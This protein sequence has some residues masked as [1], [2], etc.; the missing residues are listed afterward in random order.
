MGCPAKVTTVER[1]PSSWEIFGRV[2]RDVLAGPVAD[3]FFVVLDPE[4][5]G[6]SCD[7]EEELK[8]LE[9]LPWLSLNGAH[10]HCLFKYE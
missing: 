2:K 3:C 7:T 4:I 1:P 10:L 9:S 6:L 5:R 8:G